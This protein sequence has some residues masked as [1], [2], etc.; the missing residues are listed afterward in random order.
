[1]RFREGTIKRHEDFFESGHEGDERRPIN[2]LVA[3]GERVF[4]L[5]VDFDQQPISA[6]GGSGERH[7]FHQLAPSGSMRGIDNDGER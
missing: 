1:M 5:R 2:G 4:S 7:G 6:S 3:I